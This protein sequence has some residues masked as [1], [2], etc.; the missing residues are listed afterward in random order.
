VIL[1][2]L[3]QTAYDNICCTNNAPLPDVYFIGR[4]AY[5]LMQAKTEF[6]VKPSNFALAADLKFFQAGDL[7][8]GGFGQAILPFFC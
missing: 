3:D 6:I 4:C 1:N 8:K 2:I 5:R 7:I